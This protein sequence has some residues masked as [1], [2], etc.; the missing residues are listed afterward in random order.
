MDVRDLVVRFPL[1][2]HQSKSNRASKNLQRKGEGS[3]LFSVQ[4]GQ[5][6]LDSIILVELSLDVVVDIDQLLHTAISRC[7]GSS[8]Q[9]ECPPPFAMSR[10]ALP[11]ADPIDI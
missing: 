3:R 5:I 6:G 11:W 2:F 7:P 10:L 9:A 4:G 8:L 1:P